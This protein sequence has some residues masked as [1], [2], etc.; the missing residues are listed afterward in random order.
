MTLHEDTDRRPV[1]RGVK[2]SAVAQQTPPGGSMTID[3]FCAR[4]SIS[5][6]L[7]YTLIDDGIAPDLMRLGSIIRIS[8]AAEAKWQRANEKRTKTLPTPPSPNRKAGPGRP[9]KSAAA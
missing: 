4:N 7:F 9:K 1:K 3:V 2:P 5:R 6:S 8:T